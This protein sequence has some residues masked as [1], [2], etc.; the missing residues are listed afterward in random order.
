MIASVRG[1]GDNAITTS[2]SC[3]DGEHLFDRVG[4]VR[5]VGQVNGRVD[6][7]GQ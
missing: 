4:D 5:Y 2:S 1:Y 7:E 3:G 6:E